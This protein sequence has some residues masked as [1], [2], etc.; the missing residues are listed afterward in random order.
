MKQRKQ[1]SLIFGNLYWRT[2][3][4][5]VLLTVAFILFSLYYSSNRFYKA[6][7]TSD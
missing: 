7:E 4:G 2:S 6:F 5:I 3:F 1:D